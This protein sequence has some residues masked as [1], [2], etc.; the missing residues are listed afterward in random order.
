VDANGTETYVVWDRCKVPLFVGY[1][2]HDA[3]VV[4][5]ASNNNG[6]TWSALTCVSCEARDQFMPA[7]KTDRS[8]NIVNIAYY[9][10]KNDTTFQHRV[11]VNLMHIVP[12]N[13]T[14]DATDFHALTTL[15][16][17]PMASLEFSSGPGDHLAVAARGTGTDG[18]SRAYVH[19]S[20][21]NLQGTYNAVQ[22]P[23][24]NNHLSRLDY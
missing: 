3:D 2:C 21:N 6:N 16:N 18:Q 20:Y 24:Q 15:L 13:A 17:D 1:V 11:A 19:Y 9:S 12:G 7:I 22:S 23:D 8:R 4:M 5:K 10:S 14:P